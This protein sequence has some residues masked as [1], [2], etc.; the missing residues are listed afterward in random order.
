MWSN[1]V[2]PPRSSP[3]RQRRGFTLIEASMT[4]VIVGIGVL[5]LMELLASGTVSNIRGTEMT[6]G[7]NLAKNIRELA[8]Q[9]TFAELPAMNNAS[10]KPPIDSRGV[11]LA[12][13]SDWQQEIKVES[14]DPSLLTTPLPAATPHALRITATIN[15]NGRKVCDLQWFSF[16]P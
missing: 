6:T 13:M 5:A 14:V 10:H 16:A 9:K 3:R 11:A 7:V 12:D 15:R 1:R 4:T 2:Q 8:L